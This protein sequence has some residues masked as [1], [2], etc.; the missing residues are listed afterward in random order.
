MLYLEMIMNRFL[1]ILRWSM[2]GG[3]GTG[4][5][6]VIQIVKEELFDKLLKWNIGEQVQIVALQAVMAYLVSGDAIHHALNI[7][8]YG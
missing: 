2:H 6:H 8:A 1:S 4:E 7:Q 5:T 3:P